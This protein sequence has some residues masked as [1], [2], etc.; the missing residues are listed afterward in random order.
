MKFVKTAK[1]KAL[2]DPPPEPKGIT[3]EQA[4]DALV[5]HG[6][7]LKQVDI[8]SSYQFGSMSE[9]ELSMIVCPPPKDHSKVMS[10]IHSWHADKFFGKKF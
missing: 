6:F 9:V 3:V 1:K 8:H 10:A 5:Q 4:L 7:H 2:H